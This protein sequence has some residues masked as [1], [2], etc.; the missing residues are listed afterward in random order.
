[1]L[2]A[3]SGAIVGGATVAEELVVLKSSRE[4]EPHPMAVATSNIEVKPSR[5]ADANVSVL[6]FLIIDLPFSWSM[7]AVNF[8]PAELPSANLVDSRI[9]SKI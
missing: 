9:G 4:F 7:S 1:M 3:V 6:E 2:E 8:F 5:T